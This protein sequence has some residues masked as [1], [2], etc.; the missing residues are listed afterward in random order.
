MHTEVRGTSQ[1][2]V[3]LSGGEVCKANTSL[4]SH[5]AHSEFFIL[6]KLKKANFFKYFSMLSAE[7]NIDITAPENK[8]VD[9]I[10]SV[11]TLKAFSTSHMLDDNAPNREIF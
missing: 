4:L 7:Q 9:I 5:F 6:Q 1:E 2:L 10:I 3:I 11:G 8:Y